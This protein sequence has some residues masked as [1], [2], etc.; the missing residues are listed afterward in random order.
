[1]RR[2]P[3]SPLAGEGRGVGNKKGGG[4][5]LGFRMKISA[6][7][8]MFLYLHA[9]SVIPAEAGIQGIK[10]GFRSLP[11][12]RYGVKPGMTIREKGVMIHYTIEN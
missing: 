11:R 9:K 4:E 7:N 6:A 10:A 8:L 12:T 1:M 3:A 5:K 2:H